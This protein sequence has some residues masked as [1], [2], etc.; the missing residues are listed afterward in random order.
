MTYQEFRENFLSVISTDRYWEITPG[1]YLE[2]GKSLKAQQ[3]V[4]CDED[5]AKHINFEEFRIW[6]T[7]P[8]CLPDGYNTLEQF[9][10][11]NEWAREQ[12]K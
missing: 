10:H 11:H 12:L 5:E 9:L 2:S 8:G 4:W 3:E 7:T 6:V 1:V